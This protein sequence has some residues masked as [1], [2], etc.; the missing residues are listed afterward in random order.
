VR[1]VTIPPIQ[2]RYLP[3]KGW[4]RVT[5]SQCLALLESSRVVDTRPLL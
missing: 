5:T 3:N 1:D 4:K 2:R